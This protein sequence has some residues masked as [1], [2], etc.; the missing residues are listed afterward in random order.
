M[1]IA[2]HSSHSTTKQHM[3]T[4]MLLTVSPFHD[5]YRKCGLLNSGQQSRTTTSPGVLTDFGEL[6]FTGRFL[7]NDAYKRNLTEED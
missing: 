7:F 5:A 6:Q 1:S 2:P 3:K 4:A